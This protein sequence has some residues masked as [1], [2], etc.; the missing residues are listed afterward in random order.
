MSKIA[1]IS[2]CF[3]PLPGGGGITAAHYNLYRMFKN[4]GHEVQVFTYLDDPSLIPDTGSE[5]DIF[6][7]QTPVWRL[8]LDG[9]SE[10]LKRKY[11]KNILRKP[12]PVGLAY[13]YDLVRRSNMTSVQIN[14]DLFR[15]HPDFVFLPD[16]GVPGY[17][18]LKVPGAIYFH[19]SH[20]NPMRFMDNP[21]IE[22]HSRLDAQKAVAYEQRSLEKIDKVICVS[23]YT[24]DL[25]QKTFQF[26]GD[27]LVIPNLVN[28]SY[29]HEVPASRLREHMHLNVNDPI[30]YLPNAGIKIKGGQYLVEII[31]R[32][33]SALN[34]QVGF[35][36]SGQLSEEQKFELKHFDQFHVYVSGSI[37]NW[38]NIANMKNCTVCVSPTHTENYPMA[39]LEALFSGLPCVA[40]DA[41][42]IADL[43]HNDENGYLIPYPDMEQMIDKVLFLLQNADARKKMVLSMQ[44]FNEQFSEKAIAPQYLNLLKQ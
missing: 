37:P 31:R 21:L 43:I 34:H 12:L 24:R 36:I 44:L 5:K 41:G 38:E 22:N 11:R 18:I 19:I 13:Q 8:K 27:V 9:Y 35:Y 39:L 33:S 20:H 15:F 7:Y 29:I 1:I 2:N 30:V 16:F 14:K 32:V 17:S 25:F 40:F 28:D 6:R 42:G 26:S 4:A 3:P 23:N 10:L